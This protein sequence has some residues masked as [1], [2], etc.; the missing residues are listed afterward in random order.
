MSTKKL[1]KRDY[2]NQ[3]RTLVEDDETLVAFIDH[4]IELLDRKNARAKDGEKKLSKSQLANVE[5]AQTIYDLMETGKAYTISALIKEFDLKDAEGTPLST[6][7]VSAVV[8]VNM[9]DTLVSRSEV[10]GRAYFTK[11]EKGE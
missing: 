10:K 4:E 7:K 11:I 5:L 8:R 2:F 9:L 6:S 1:T 3:L